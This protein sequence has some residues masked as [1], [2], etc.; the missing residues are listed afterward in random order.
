MEPSPGPRHDRAPT[1]A[2]WP[3]AVVRAAPLES[4]ARRRRDAPA[5]GFRRPARLRR[6]AGLLAT[7]LLA[8]V[9]PF[10]APAGNA[11]AQPASP[12]NS[13]PPPAERIYVP[14]PWPPFAPAFPFYPGP[15]IGYRFCGAVGW[16][17]DRPPRRPVAPEPPS[18]ADPDLWSTT[19]SPW[20]YVR[21]LPPPTPA[22]QIQPRYRDASTIRPEFAARAASAP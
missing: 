1:R 6:C 7:V 14:Y 8:T 5:P 3:R 10:A 12:S 11:A 19:G 18:P 15:C 20:G 4:A 16:W 2:E 13:P 9:V 21:R 22:D 17:N